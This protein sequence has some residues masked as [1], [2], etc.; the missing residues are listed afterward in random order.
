[1]TYTPINWQTGDTITAEKMNKMDN[2]WSVT[3]SVTTIC[4][5]T[6]TTYVDD[7]DNAAELSTLT[8][9][10]EADSIVVTYD[11]TVYTCTNDGDMYGAPYEDYSQY[12]FT[13]YSDGFMLC[14]TSGTHSVK[15]EVD[16]K[17]VES[18]QSFNDAVSTALPIM[19]IAIEKTTWQEARDAL[20]AGKLV[21][22]IVDV[23]GD[24]VT[25]FVA[26]N[27]HY[28]DDNQQYEILSVGAPSDGLATGDVLYAAK[29]A[30]ALYRQ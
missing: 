10:I 1:M 18:S 17:T 26:L 12:P 9:P 29:S 30:G 28:S 8:G 2:G 3:N 5:E 19:Q 15:I 4:D 25:Q 27:A 24:T 14:E 11:N 20:A 16:V 13:I 6:V 21:F 23:D 22:Y 7:S